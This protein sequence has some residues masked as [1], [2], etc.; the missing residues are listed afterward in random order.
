MTNGNVKYSVTSTFHLATL[1]YRNDFGLA[2]CGFLC[3]G[4][5]WLVFIGQKAL[6]VFDPLLHVFIL[7]IQLS[8]HFR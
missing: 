8:C 1:L 2:S 5:A 4:I 6:A 7:C 3:G